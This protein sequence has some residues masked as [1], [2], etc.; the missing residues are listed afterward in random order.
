ML[1]EWATSLTVSVELASVERI[2]LLPSV[3]HD[4]S[5][6]HHLGLASAVLADPEHIGHDLDVGASAVYAH[7]S[8][9]DYVG[10][11]TPASTVA[12]CP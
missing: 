3:P 4:L 9:L 7:G 10:H 12:G 6:V 2:M 8:S 5:A 1:R 11:R